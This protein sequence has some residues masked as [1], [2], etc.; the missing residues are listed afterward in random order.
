MPEITIPD[1]IQAM[2]FETALEELETLVAKMENGGL[3][4]EELM[5]GFERGRLLTEHC[6][7]KLAALERRITVL[8]RDDGDQGQW[9]DFAP[10]NSRNRPRDHEENDLPF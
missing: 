3:P 4:L 6:R 1:D 5:T 7:N 8:T 9:T 10:E 2:P